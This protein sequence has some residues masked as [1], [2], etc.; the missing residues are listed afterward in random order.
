MK[1]HGVSDG[2]LAVRAHVSSS[3]SHVLLEESGDRTIL[4][5]PHAAGTIG[6][7]E[8]EASFAPALDRGVRLVTT[9]V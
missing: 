9:E 4:M 3:V 7:A 1:V 2:A 5:A 6:A 8:V